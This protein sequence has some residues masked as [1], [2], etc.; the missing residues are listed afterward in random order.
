MSVF[1]RM[2]P[3]DFE[4]VVFC[5]DA[6][7]GLRSIIAVHD[8]SLGPALGGVRMRAYPREED[9]LTDCLR[10]ARGMTFKA[11]IAGV[12]LGGG[13]SVIIGD[14]K[15]DKTEALLKAHGR[16]IQTLHGRYIPGMD[17]GTEM[18]DLEVIATEADRV[19][20]VRNDPS[21]MTAL[22]VLEGIKACV[23]ARFGTGS[24]D[25]VKV[26]VQGVGH[27]G[28]SLAGKLVAEG[29][30]VTVADADGPRAKE[31]AGEI[32]ATKV[33]ADALLATPCDVLAPC[34]YGG[35]IDDSTVDTLRCAIVAGGANNVLAEPRHGEEL[36][37][38]GILYAPDYCI[39][40]GGLISLEE[41]ILG[42]DEQRTERRVRSVGKLVADVLR[43]AEQDGVSP[44][45]AA[46]AM[47][48]E[49]LTALSAVGPKYVSR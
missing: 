47:A 1:D 31:V 14:P 34:A 7:T 25:G 43:R 12:N 17:S 35:V 39:N 37:A 27:V 6:N 5:H 15:H 2:V 8:T 46:T 3:D 28:S 23:H 26:C 38:R 11:A 20:C 42:H 24:L 33:D 45:H 10:L 36:Q 41:E 9:A 49:R 16:F 4:Q 48:T 13:K 29:A 30:E 21:P 19:S 44:A 18:R 32:G 22:G 40:A